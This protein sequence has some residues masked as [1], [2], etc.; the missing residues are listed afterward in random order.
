MKR[1]IQ[2]ILS[3]L[4]F[5]GVLAISVIGIFVLIAI[6]A[7]II[8]PHDPRIGSVL[9]KLQSPSS[10]YIL[11][12]DEAG[13][14]IFSRLVWGARSALTGSFVVVLLAAIAA[15]ILAFTAAW[16]GGIV[17]N[18]ISRVMDVLFAF[19]N[20]LLAMLAIALFG[21]SQWIAAIALAIA[22]T[23]YSMRVIR[24]VAI[25]ERRLP[26]V[27]ASRL[28]GIRGNVVVVRHMLPNVY[29]HIIN[30]MTIIFGFAMM[31]LSALSFLGMGVQLPNADWGLM[32]SSGKQSLINGSPMES[33]A[34]GTCI[35]VIVVCFTAV[36]EK[37]RD[38][39]LGKVR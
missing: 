24:S 39:S 14:D 34:A 27:A 29:P 4:G 35:V 16:F 38:R 30:G 15:T 23:P 12:T 1:R 28:Q 9:Q 18:L 36:G 11:G 5:F 17:D 20:M 2:R 33:L 19:P 7:P 26:Y 37:L 32:V 22:Y 3:E 21:S 6:F 8:A 25:R 10:E 13:R 31:E